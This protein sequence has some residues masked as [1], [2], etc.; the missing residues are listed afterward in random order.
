[1]IDMNSCQ[2]SDRLIDNMKN[3]FVVNRTKQILETNSI[4]I[5]PCED[6]FNAHLRCYLVASE[7][8]YTT[9]NETLK[10]EKKICLIG[11][12]IGRSPDWGEFVRNHPYFEG[13]WNEERIETNVADLIGKIKDKIAINA[14]IIVLI[15]TIPLAINEETI[16]KNALVPT[17]TI[18]SEDQGILAKLTNDP[19]INGRAK[20]VVLSFDPEK[21]P[22]NIE[23]PPGYREK[24]ASSRIYESSQYNLIKIPP[25]ADDNTFYK[26]SVNLISIVH[27]CIDSILN[28][29]TE[30]LEN[31]YSDKMIGRSKQFLKLLE[32]IDDAAQSDNRVIIMGE[33]GVGK[34]LVARA[35]HEKSSRSANRLKAKNCG[36]IHKDLAESELFGYV[37]G[38]FTG[39]NDKG[40]EGLFEAANHGTLF[41]DEVG[42]L[43]L[44]TQ[45]T[46]LRA[47]Q[48][49]QI[50]RVGSTEEIKID[51]RVIV[52]TNKDLTKMVNEGSFREDLWYRLEQDVIYVPSLN[53][54]AEDIPLLAEYFL[55][56][57]NEKSKRKIVFDKR[58][59]LPMQRKQWR[60]NIRE[61]D[62]FVE[63]L[64]SK[65]KGGD[66]IT[67]DMVNSLIPM[68]SPIKDKVELGALITL[69]KIAAKH[70]TL[71]TE[72][73]GGNI[74]HAA[75]KLDISEKTVR[76][77]IKQYKSDNPSI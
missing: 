46:L 35:I 59:F 62:N 44:N 68:E 20:I 56:E 15:N 36:S 70:T 45:S 51:V 14:D 16:L 5:D 22:A 1:M 18:D 74:T 23:C 58:A 65:C 4:E 29:R 19:E 73:M 2:L 3:Q 77:N 24:Y 71:V 60:G 13:V 39:A 10:L 47:L 6:Y 76:K 61:L 50:V 31:R 30:K 48:E 37:K 67:V 72:R 55:G 52:A 9:K 28:E 42:E 53:E 43:P 12:S 17:C 69:E 7:R 49:N 8:K 64:A 66:V 34:E 63:R 57:Y 21:V 38:A 26:E 40:S 41:L 33:S 27:D 54:R 75:K 25:R 11:C 32:Q